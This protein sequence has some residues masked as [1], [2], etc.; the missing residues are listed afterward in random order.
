MNTSRVVYVLLEIQIGDMA[1]ILKESDT[2]EA[3][4]LINKDHPYEILGNKC[5]SDELAILDITGEPNGLLLPAL[6]MLIVKTDTS[7]PFLGTNYVFLTNK[8]FAIQGMVIAIGDEVGLNTSD[9]P[10]ERLVKEEH[11]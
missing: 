2:N 11:Q 7:L 6:N 3:F 4:K 5:T 9:Y 1:L 8:G 10:I